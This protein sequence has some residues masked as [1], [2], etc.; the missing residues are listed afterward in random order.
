M[1]DGGFADVVGV[2]NFLPAGGG[3]VAP[4]LIGAD[5]VEGVLVGDDGLGVTVRVVHFFPLFVQAWPV[6]FRSRWGILYGFRFRV[7]VY[8]VLG[9]L[10]LVAF[11]VVKS[12]VKT[13]VLVR[14][15]YR[16]SFRQCRTKASSRSA[17]VALFHGLLDNKANLRGGVLANIICLFSRISSRVTIVHC[18]LFRIDF[19]LMKLIQSLSAF[20]LVFSVNALLTSSP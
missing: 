16:V 17:L 18:S 19:S 4:E 13:L 9:G 1:P 10:R 12:M 7:V 15:A 14:P 11:P 5:P 3:Q 8:A 2:L 20:P 6:F